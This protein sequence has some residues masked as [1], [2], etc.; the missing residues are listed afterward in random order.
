MFLKQP[1]QG[2]AS[3]SHFKVR[4]VS[5]VKLCTVFFSFYTFWHENSEN[6]HKHEN[7]TNTSTSHNVN[8]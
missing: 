7:N 1:N 6:R 3:F 4:Y 2:V 8:S 5:F